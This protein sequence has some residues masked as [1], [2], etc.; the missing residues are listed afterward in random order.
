MIDYTEWRKY[1]RDELTVQSG[2]RF[3]VELEYEKSRGDDGGVY[4]VRKESEPDGS[5]GR[6]TVE[7]ERKIEEVLLNVDFTRVLYLLWYH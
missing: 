3:Y 7:T 6:S 2:Q 4:L 5:I 1:H